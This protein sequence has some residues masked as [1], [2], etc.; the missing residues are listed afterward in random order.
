ML[1]VANIN[2]CLRSG[3][4]RF[5]SGKSLHF[6]KFSNIEDGRRGIIYDTPETHSFMTGLKTNEVNCKIT[7]LSY[8]VNRLRKQLQVVRSN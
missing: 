2:P 7:K 3:M 1:I 5:F 4:S 8:Q 6:Q